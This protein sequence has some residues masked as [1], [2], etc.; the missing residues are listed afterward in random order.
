MTE[1]PTIP[2]A[3]LLLGQI[4]AAAGADNLGTQIPKDLLD[5][6]PFVMGVRFGGAPTDPRFLDRATVSLDV[7]DDDR[8]GAHDTAWAM[9]LALRDAALSQTVFDA[10]HVAKFQPISA[11]SELRTPDQRDNVWRFNATASL[12]IRP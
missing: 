4:F 5:R 3:D 7:W 9:W 10:G 8:K 11:P 12:V 6:L 1:L 2:D